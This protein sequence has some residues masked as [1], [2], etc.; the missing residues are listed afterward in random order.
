MKGGMFTVGYVSIF[1]GF[2]I[3]TSISTGIFAENSLEGN[4]MPSGL[5]H[6]CDGIGSSAFKTD[7]EA[8]A[9]KCFM[10][11][12]VWPQVSAMTDEIQKWNFMLLIA[13]KIFTPA[14]IGEIKRL[15]KNGT[16][17]L[18]YIAQNGRVHFKDQTAPF[19]SKKF[20]ND[21]AELIGIPFRDVLTKMNDGA[22]DC[23]LCDTALENLGTILASFPGREYERSILMNSRTI[24]FLA[25][26]LNKTMILFDQVPQNATPREERLKLKEALLSARRKFKQNQAVLLRIYHE[27]FAL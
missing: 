14:E 13:D 12:E 15:I 27:Y 11:P 17:L 9:Q 16:G 22:T 1:L 26:D 6:A 21:E 4:P 8:V 5:D 23:K 18:D 10:Q 2:I 19:S 7:C 3:T 20:S 25:K 24:H